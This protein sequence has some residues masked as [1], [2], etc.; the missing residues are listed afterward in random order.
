MSTSFRSALKHRCSA[1]MTRCPVVMG[2]SVVA[3][4]AGIG[5]GLSLGR[6]GPS[7]QLGAGFRFDFGGTTGVS[8]LKTANGKVKTIYDLQGRKLENPTN[9]IYY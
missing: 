6:E 7:V 5:T 9:G 3:G 4:V 8:E 2:L 1:M